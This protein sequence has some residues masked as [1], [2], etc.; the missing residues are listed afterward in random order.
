NLIGNALKYSKQDVP[1]Q[2]HISSRKV[3][4]MEVRNHL[5]LGNDEKDYYLIEVKDNGV[6]FEQKDAERI[7]NVFTRLYGNAEYRGSGIGLS[8]VR[9]VAENHKGWVWAESRP[10]EGASFKLLLPVDN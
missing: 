2:I 9:K 6:G 5:P 1:P 4:G 7:F 8:I 10:E 3:K